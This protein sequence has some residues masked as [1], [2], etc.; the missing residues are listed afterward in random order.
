MVNFQ[1]WCLLV[2]AD[3]Y[4]TGEMLDRRLGSRSNTDNSNNNG[5]VPIAK[6]GMVLPFTPLAMS[7]DDVNYFVD[8]PG[9]SR[10]TKSLKS[11]GD[12]G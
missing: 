3:C 2:C 9:V 8:M 4:S 1:L 12:V 10:S 5:G 6:K 7:F 11:V